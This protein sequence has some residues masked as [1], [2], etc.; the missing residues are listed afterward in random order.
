MSR[1]V[2][3]RSTTRSAVAWGCTRVGYRRI[4]RRHSKFLLEN[5]SRIPMVF[6]TQLLSLPI[7]FTLRKRGLLDV[8]G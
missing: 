8:P 4:L 3:S 7:T 1:L 6:A 5:K 2:V